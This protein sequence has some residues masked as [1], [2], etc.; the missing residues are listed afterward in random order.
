M[1][2]PLQEL[3]QKVYLLYTLQHYQCREL[4]DIS[5]DMIKIKSSGYGPNICIDV[6]D[7]SKGAVYEVPLSYKRD[8]EKFK[9]SDSFHEFIYDEILRIVSELNE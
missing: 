2:S 5:G 1:E 4:G 7:E 8:K 9:L 6:S 3:T